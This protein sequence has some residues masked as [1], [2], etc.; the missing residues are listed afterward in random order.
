MA[1]LAP[2]MVRVTLGGPELAGFT[3]QAPTDHV[4]IALPAP[5][6]DEPIIPG[7]DEP[8]APGRDRPILRSYTVRYHRPDRNEIDIDFVLH[9]DGPAANWAAQAKPGQ[10]LGVLGPRGSVI[11][12]YDFDWYLFAGDETALPAIGAWLEQVPATATVVALL[13]VAD[14]TAELDLR[15]PAG[16]RL[17]WLHRA[18]GENLAAAIEAFAAAGGADPPGGDGYLWVAGEATTLRPIRRRLREA[19]YQW[20]HVDGYWRRGVASPN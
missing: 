19:G 20:F 2:A 5:G 13:E 10:I 9:G 15:H 3:Y 11:V 4:Q 16:T 8:I 12:P 1:R 18:R 7:R 14:Q 6:R 17:R